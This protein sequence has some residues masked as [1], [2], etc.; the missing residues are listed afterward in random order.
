VALAV[1]DKLLQTLW[2][3]QPCIVVVDKKIVR[4]IRER[5]S[6]FAPEDE[7]PALF[8]IPITQ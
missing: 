4:L 8:P 3:H 2:V 5:L 1:Y 7:L 6:L